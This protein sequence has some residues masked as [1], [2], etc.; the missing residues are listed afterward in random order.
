MKNNLYRGLTALT[1]ST[2]LLGLS[3]SCTKDLDQTPKYELSPDKVYVGLNG[4]KQVLAKLYGGFALS[5]SN[6]P[7]SGDITG[8]DAGTSNYLRQ[9]W[10]AQEI[11]TDEAVIAWN[12]PGLQD[13]HNLNWDSNNP[14]IRG[15]YNRC[16]YQIA[17][18][19][20]FIRESA[21]DKLGSRLAGA[22]VAQ[23]KVFRAEARF[24]RAVSY[25]HIIDLFGNGPFV[26]EAN[27]IGG[28]APQYYTRKQLYDFV[29]SELLALTTEL[30]PARTNEYGRID[31]AAAH[32]YLAR[33]YLNAGVYTGTPQF[34]KAADEA[35]KV[36]DSGYTLVTAASPASSAYGRNFLADNNLPPAANEIIWPVIFDVSRVQSYGG[37]TFLVNGATSG[38]DGA[39]QRYVGQSTGWGGLRTTSALVDKF[40]LAGGDTLKDT[41]G[42]F[43]TPGQT[44]AINDLSQFTQGLGVTKYRN[45]T[46]AGVGQGGPQ[47]FSSVDFPMLRLSDMMLT[48]A[49]AAIEGGGSRATALEY[50]NQLRARAF[51]GSTGAITDAQMTK[52]FIL[53]ERARELHWEG[54]RRTDLIRHNQF[55]TATYLWPWKGGVAAGRS[56]DVY[57]SLF[58]IPSSDITVNP[59]L[60]Q[61]PGY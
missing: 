37:T 18:C 10:S 41:R 33:L 23:G 28:A 15:L 11:T 6:G 50:V 45:I 34:A 32:G 29:E 61:N 1:L 21:D 55:T 42:R 2:A 26:T 36:V 9:L 16:Y 14:L 52:Q 25:S 56:V 60:K 12:D 53:D 17:T 4:Y 44:L 54:T 48:Y 7:D 51:K 46:S 30:A 31:Q 59:N 58:P 38:V 19:N 24:L 22:E 47:N 3:T 57:R 5:G 13:W 8:I 40:F 49:E 43:W 27:E 20:E 35:K 39:W